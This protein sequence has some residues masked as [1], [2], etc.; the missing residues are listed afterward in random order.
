M[1]EGFL[2][3]RAHANSPAVLEWVAGLADR[4]F[5]GLK[6]RGRMRLGTATYR[7]PRCGLLQSYAHSPE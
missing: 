2:V 5:F 1:Q 4:G 3:D 7:C 6:L